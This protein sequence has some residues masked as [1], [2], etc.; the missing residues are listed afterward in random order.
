MVAGMAD[1]PT[2][3]DS[4]AGEEEQPAVENRWWVDSGA[5]KTRQTNPTA[6]REGEP[7][8]G[9]LFAV[10]ADF[11]ESRAQKTLTNSNLNFIEE[12]NPSE[13]T[14][15]YMLVAE[16]PSSPQ[17][18]ARIKRFLRIPKWA[19]GVLVD[20][21]TSVRAIATGSPIG[22]RVIELTLGSQSSFD[23]WRRGEWVR[24]K[25]FRSRDRALREASGLI[26]RYL[27]NRDDIE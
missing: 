12:A 16:T 26:H 8:V 18:L 17:R 2:S 24:E 5:K 21:G 13:G 3:D 1:R 7:I 6:T 25:T 15:E 9:S 27:K 11:D 22:D 14:W 20:S 19:R 23:A 4:P 10:G